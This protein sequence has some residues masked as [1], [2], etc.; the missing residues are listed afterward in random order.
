MVPH[1]NLPQVLTI[2]TRG[3]ATLDLVI[4]NSRSF[5]NPPTGVAPTAT[6]DHKIVIWDPKTSICTN[7]LAQVRKHHR[8]FPQ[9]AHQAFG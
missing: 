9:S 4:T 7:L 8:C 3:S 5:Y 6:S 2:P 1:H